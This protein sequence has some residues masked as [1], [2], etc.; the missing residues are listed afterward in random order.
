MLQLTLTDT[1]IDSAYILYLRTG[2]RVVQTDPSTN[3]WKGVSVPGM[4]LCGACPADFYVSPS[5]T[6][7]LLARYSTL[8]C[9]EENRF[10]AVST[11]A[12]K[13]T[14]WDTRSSRPDG[15]WVCLLERETS[16]KLNAL[17]FVRRY[18][19]VEAGSGAIGLV[20]A[21][22]MGDVYIFHISYDGDEAVDVDVPRG[23]A[24]TDFLAG[25]LSTVTAMEFTA[26]ESFL[27]TAERDEKIRV[28]HFPN[29][30]N[31][32]AFCLGH[33]CHVSALA[34]ATIVQHPAATPLLLSGA[35]DGSLKLW[36]LPGSKLL[37]SIM[38]EK[39]AA[40]ESAAAAQPTE[41]HPARKPHH[42][43]MSIVH[44]GS[45]AVDAIAY[46]PAGQVAAVSFSGCGKRR[47]S[48]TFFQCVAN[49]RNGCTV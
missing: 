25:H 3:H 26:D 13:L 22:R 32:E 18:H 33:T 35:V 39:P 23:D 24:Q 31:I 28:S 12:K 19:G 48:L 27:V 20:V 45:V 15:S 38:L 47:D 14:V 21:D 17:R 11:D 8:A 30:Y 10:V 40:A 2:V 9:C 6:E 36:S 43:N 46:M 7:T 16:K 49:A 1:S 5:L 34:V 37:H 29:S 4:A 42:A 44:D 41:Q